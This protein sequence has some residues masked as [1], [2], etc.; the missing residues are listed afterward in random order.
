MNTDGA[1]RSFSPQVAPVLPERLI[2]VE[3]VLGLLDS[4]E[5]AEPPS[6]LVARTMARIDGALDVR[7]PRPFRSPA[8]SA[9]HA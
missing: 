1:S 7:E 9:T 3:Q 2:A 6:D 8:E 5:V 4:L